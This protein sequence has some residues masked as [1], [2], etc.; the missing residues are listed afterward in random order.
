MVNDDG[1]G[2]R[3]IGVQLA[4]EVRA[5]MLDIH[6]M[7][8]SSQALEKAVEHLKAA[9]IS[10]D[11][12]IRLR[13]YEQENRTLDKKARSKLADEARDYSLFQGERNP[14]ASPVRTNTEITDEGQKLLIGITS[15]DRCR[16]GPP[17]LVH[18]G[19]LAGIFDDLLSGTIRFVVK[20]PAVTGRLE[21]RYRRPTPIDTELRFEA[22]VERNNGRRIVSRARCL[23]DN[24]LT[25]EAE[26][27]FVTIPSRG[28][29]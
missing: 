6:R 28:L 14:I 15:V 13:W 9:R 2:D 5:L 18:G 22:W 27:L 29:I 24:V 21:V 25:A 4:D 1:K 11:G 16:E 8:C 20:G 7:D 19:Y 3:E 23:V 12:S 10:L 17:G 26:A